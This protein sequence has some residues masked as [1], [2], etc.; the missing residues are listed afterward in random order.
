MRTRWAFLAI[1]AMGTAA[2]Q[3]EEAAQPDATA[4]QATKATR[5][6]ASDEGEPTRR[7]SHTVR[8]RGQALEVEARGAGHV[9]ANDHLDVLGTFTD[10]RTESSVTVTLLQNVIVLAPPEVNPG[11][12]PAHVLTLLVLPE[13]AEVLALAGHLGELHVSLRHPEDVSGLGDRKSRASIESLITWELLKALNKRRF[14]LLEKSKSA[15]RL[16]RAPGQDPG[17]ARLSARVPTGFRALE[18]PVTGIRHVE[19]GD[20]VDLLL[21][22][23]SPKTGQAICRTATVG[24]DVLAVDGGQRLSVLVL[25]EETEILALAARLGE[26][27]AALRNPDD[28]FVISERASVTVEALITG[29]RVKPLVRARQQTIQVI[30]LPGSGGGVIGGYAAPEPT[31]VSEQ[32]EDHGDN[33]WTDTDRDRQSTFAVDVDTGSYTIARRK[34]REVVLPP[35]AAVRTEEFI[36][37]FRYDYPPPRRGPFALDLEA[38]PSPFGQQRTLLRV[39]I[40][41]REVARQHRKP[42]RLTFLVDTSGSM[43]SPDKLG[44]VKRS[45]R[46]LVDQLQPDDTVALAT[47]AGRVAEVLPPTGMNDRARIHWA[48]EELT[49]GGSTAMDSGLKAAY[50]LAWRN[51]DKAASNRVIVC[52]DG[53]ANVGATSHGDMLQSI[54]YYAERGVSLS[55]IGFGT[56]NYKDHKMEQLADAGNGNYYYIDG[57]PQAKRVFGEDL[58]GTLQVIARDV[59]VQVEFDPRAVARYRLVG[60]ENRAIADEDFRDDDVDAG[61]IGAGHAVTALYELELRDR[62]RDWGTVRIRWEKPG[63]EGRADERQVA[64]AP[65]VEA[66]SFAQASPS[67]QRAVVAAGLAEHLRE[68]PARQDWSLDTLEKLARKLARR[69]RGKV[70][71]DDDELVELYALAAD[72]LHGKKSQHQ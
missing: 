42:L 68:S 55:T 47:Y 30:R 2:C 50:G 71:A 58:S 36:N 63:G 20:R 46:F 53:D 18:I 52:S 34:L 9:R 27:T 11:E 4:A 60:Y 15:D 38:A 44:L 70:A 3:P 67:L 66:G 62:S 29:E 6:Q 13:E 17:S 25:P 7:L 69:S 54:E 19:P 51:F 28:D 59:K 32:Y 16:E 56:G 37:Y 26:L 24:L 43:R 10:P 12:E 35:P 23:A 49:A 40:K 21:T 14:L 33:P 31:G 57:Y 72:L 5:P 8:K 1:L 65:T 45:L 64:I 41:G 22:V 39:G 48:I 61:E